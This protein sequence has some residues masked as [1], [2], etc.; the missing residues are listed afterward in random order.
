MSR[1]ASPGWS[2]PG[3]LTRRER[4][5]IRA[6]W[7]ELVEYLAAPG[8]AWEWGESGLSERLKHYLRHH[9]L[10]VRDSDDGSKWQTT[11]TLWVAVLQD[12]SD[13]ET[14]GRGAEGQCKLPVEAQASSTPARRRSSGVLHTTAAG[15]GVNGTRQATLTG[16]VIDPSETVNDDATDTE[17]VERNLSKGERDDPAERGDGQ[18][19]LTRWT[20]IDADVNEWDV[21]VDADGPRLRRIDA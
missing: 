13:D 21:T 19:P 10:I 14:I 11:E 18:P 6:N 4:A 5:T 12:A 9:G 1:A 2:S 20:G 7:G 16:D 8:I 17:L 3:D 15:S